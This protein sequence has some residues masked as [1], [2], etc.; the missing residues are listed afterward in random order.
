MNG[1][2]SME[3]IVGMLLGVEE[4][5]CGIVGEGHFEIYIKNKNTEFYLFILKK[6]DEYS[7][8]ALRKVKRGTVQ[9]SET[10]GEG[11]KALE[12]SLKVLYIAS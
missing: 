7:P 1:R 2:K 6:A 5:A 8:R 11:P 10:E 9:R 4:G 3:K 12:K